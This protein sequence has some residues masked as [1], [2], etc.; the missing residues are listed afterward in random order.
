[1]TVP[2]SSTG[3]KIAGL[4]LPP[5]AVG[6]T[7]RTGS[8]DEETS[9][10][11]LPMHRRLRSC[12]GAM[13]TA[14]HLLGQLYGCSVSA[15]RST[16]RNLH[17]RLPM[18]RL[19]RQYL[20]G[21]CNVA[22]ARVAPR[23]DRIA[24]GLSSGTVRQRIS[25][26]QRTHSR[27][28]RCL[29]QVPWSRDVQCEWCCRCE[30]HA[31]V[32]IAQSGARQPREMISAKSWASIR[33]SMHVGPYRAELICVLGA[34]RG[35][36]SW[37]PCGAAARRAPERP[38]Q[39]RLGRKAPLICAK[40]GRKVGERAFLGREEPVAAVGCLSAEGVAIER[41]L[42]DVSADLWPRIGMSTYGAVARYLSSQHAYLHRS[43]ALRIRQ[44]P[45]TLSGAGR[46]QERPGQ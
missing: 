9:S 20:P 15:T 40:V 41:G 3:G 37:P 10:G 23:G 7:P 32:A 35:N 24:C 29:S 11:S 43:A 42:R 34:R 26:G 12:L 1:L 21:A 31:L 45:T 33:M 18:F 22:S 30:Q 39:S 38:S 2:F 46:G 27:A 4:A 14:L 6:L 17:G 13:G 44:T 36:T 8:V 28:V 5:C 16:R 19:D 25:S